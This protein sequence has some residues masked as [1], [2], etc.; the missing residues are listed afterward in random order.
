MLELIAQPR[1]SATKAKTLRSADM[2]PAELYGHGVENRHLAVPRKDFMRVFREAGE[3]TVITVAIGEKDRRPVMIYGVDF[4]PLTDEAR[5]IDFYQVRL[6]EKIS[7]KAPLEVVGVSL[8]VKEKGGVLLRAMHDIEIEALPNDLPS[9]ITVD[10]SGLSDIGQ[11]IYVKD[12]KLGAAVSTSVDP[13]TVIVSVVAKVTE[14]EEAK[15]AAEAAALKVEEVKV[16]TEEKK[17]EREAV[18]ETAPP[19]AEA[20]K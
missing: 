14:E 12:L 3:N 1:E 13:A 10:I 18:K 20:P 19:E 4:D 7:V 6:D 5:N 15:L 8:A 9:K 17:A 11:S 16:E 2:I